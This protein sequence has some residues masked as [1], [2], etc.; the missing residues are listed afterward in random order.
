MALTSVPSARL[1]PVEGSRMVWVGLIVLGISVGAFGTLIGAGGGFLLVPI[2][3]LMYP[4]EPPELIAS[5]SLAVVFFNALSGSISYARMKRIDYRAGLAFSAASIPGAILG[6]RT[7]ASIERSTFDLLLGIM[8]VFGSIAM[9]LLGSRIAPDAGAHNAPAPASRRRL[10]LGAAISFVVG[11]ISTLLGIGGGIIHVPL[12]VFALGFP[13]HAAT[14]TS[15]FVLALTALAG[16]SQHL[17]AG[18]FQHGVRRTIA[19]SAGALIGAPLGARLSRNAH[20]AWI[21]RSLA[22]A[23]CLVG[24][25]LMWASV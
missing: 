13:V 18:I 17:A 1:C 12:L 8:L 23:L 10:A 25:R 3:A 21:V 9:L 5:I 6:A 19:I 14:A 24:L 22:I 7:T 11:Y 16:T 2:L 20:P 15:H 4:E